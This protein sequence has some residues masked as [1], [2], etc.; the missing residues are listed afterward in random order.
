MI[1]KGNLLIHELI[2][3]DVE[4]ARCTDRKMAGTHGKVVDETANTFVVKSGGRE[5]TIPKKAC[6]FRFTL[7]DGE[8]VDVDGGLI[9]MDP[10]ERPKK[11]A[12]YCRL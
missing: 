5:L 6:V 1:A 2:S 10:V 8:K 3:L 9:A 12:K 4:V 11:L 7:P